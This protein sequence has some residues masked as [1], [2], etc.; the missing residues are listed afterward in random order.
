M[1]FLVNTVYHW[2]SPV[3]ETFTFPRL[4]F[5]W[6]PPR[7]DT[8]ST[9][10][11]QRSRGE[12]I[13]ITPTYVVSREPLESAT[14][15]SL[16]NRTAI[17]NWQLPFNSFYD[18]SHI[19]SIWRRFSDYECRLYSLPKVKT[20]ILALHCPTYCYR[21]AVRLADPSSAL[22]VSIVGTV[23][24]RWLFWLKISI[25]SSLFRCLNRRGSAII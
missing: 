17:R 22:K 11:C 21:W 13:Q 10:W 18:E 1:W 19:I 14:K 4:I 6:I 20:C 3:A 9:G 16:V 15:R 5:P 8:I 24:N 7:R 23:H 2:R 25:Y 12:H